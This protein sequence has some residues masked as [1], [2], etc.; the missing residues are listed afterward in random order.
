[1]RS[2]VG[3]RCRFEASRMMTSDGLSSATVFPSV[4][5]RRWLK[6]SSLGWLGAGLPSLFELGRSRADE[7]PARPRRSPIKSVIV[8]F[9]YGGPSHLDT[10][11]PKP[12]A[13]TQVRGEYQTIA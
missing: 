5:R 9:H 3:Q 1:M 2:P 13:A 11:D 7:R 8:V 6:V 12:L 10:Y 4:S